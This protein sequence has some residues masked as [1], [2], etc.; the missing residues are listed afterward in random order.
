MVH[1]ADEISSA[2]NKD[3]VAHSDSLVED[4][5]EAADTIIYCAMHQKRIVDDIL[6]LSKLDSD[7]LVISPQ[8]AVLSTIIRQALKM[9][10]AE[11]SRADISL[12][13]HEDDSL[14]GDNLWALFDPGRVL[15][16]FVNFMTNAIKFTRFEENRHIRVEIS[17]SSSK[18]TALDQD[19]KYIPK[20]KG[21]QDQ[22]TGLDCKDGNLVFL[23][24]SVADTGRGLTEEEKA[25]LFNVFQQ[26]SPKT[27]VQYGGS[28][29]GLFIC[30]QLVEMQGGEIGV[31][32]KVGKGSTFSCYIKARITEAPTNPQLS[33]EGQSS[34]MDVE[35]LREA[36][37]GEI[38][39]HNRRGVEDSLAAQVQSLNL[40]A[41][42][43]KH[44]KILHILVVE[45]NLINQKVVS[46]QLQR[47]G[48]VVNVAN[49]GVEALAFI[50][51][52]EHYVGVPV[53]EKLS[54]I[55]M[56]LEMPVMDGLTCV[57]EIRQLQLHGR[58]HGHIPVIATTANARVDQ[59]AEAMDA[60][61]VRYISFG[62]MESLTKVLG[63]RDYK[64][65][66]DTRYH[67]SGGKSSGKN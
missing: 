43:N 9:F 34:F 44:H 47:H 15:Q 57:K 56:D 1:C 27:Y 48:C 23:S 65:I 29:L 12:H 49:H 18:P 51:R 5:I 16:I 45:D 14:M 40:S 17:A 46:K 67:K 53:G 61:M 63:P 31:A 66:P 37:G 41:P 20:R 38:P 26:A 54:V 30:R 50:R 55:L 21:F 36:S 52:S 59:I 28:G 3:L 35:A 22:T 58:I 64:A 6:T 8:P 42:S 11:M 10:E 32:S 2:L 25:L 19:T 62:D 24:I 4:A 7:L 13:L 39:K 33:I 60:G